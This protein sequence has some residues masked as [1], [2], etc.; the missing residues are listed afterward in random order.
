M[1]SFPLSSALEQKQHVA[2]LIYALVSVKNIKYE[3]LT[4]MN[5]VEGIYET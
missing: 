1:L 4:H 5:L 3:P 2:T